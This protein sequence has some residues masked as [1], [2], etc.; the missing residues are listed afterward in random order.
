MKIFIVAV[1]VLPVLVVGGLLY[2]GQKSAGGT[3]PGLKEGKLAPCPAS[4]NCVSS[5]VGT[6]EDKLVEPFPL[7]IWGRIPSVIEDMGGNIT[8]QDADYIAAEFTSRIFRFVDDIEFRRGD[9]HVHVR[10][11]SRVGRSDLGANASRV[12][13]LRDRLSP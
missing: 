1:L 13:Q 11:A 4:P 7:T 5:E 3:A 6:P 8:A 9:E 12:A 2:L 10:S